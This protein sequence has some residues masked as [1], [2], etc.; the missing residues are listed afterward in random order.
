MA[1]L[2]KDGN[3]DQLSRRGVLVGSAAAGAILSR[4]LTA[5]AETAPPPPEDRLSSVQALIEA[6]RAGSPELGAL[7]ARQ[8]PGLHRGGVAAVT[9]SETPPVPG[10]TSVPTRASGNV[11]A[12][13]GQ[14]FL[15]AVSS[16][17]PVTVSIDERPPAPM[18]RVAGTSY[19]FRLE[20]LRLGTTHTFTYIV[21]DRAVGTNGVAGYNPDSYELPGV[22][23]G[24]LSDM[25]T[26]TSRIYPGATAKYWVYV[27]P[28]A[29]TDR[30]APLMVWQDGPTYVGAA[31]LINYRLQI[32]SDNLVHKKLIPPMVHVLIAPGTGGEPQPMRY[33]GDTQDNE[34]RSLQYDSVSDRYGR[35]LLEDVLP[36]V[37]KT[38]KLRQDSYSRGIAGL[39]SGAICAFNAAWFHP[40]Q[41]SRVH[42][43]IGSYTALQ[44]HPDQHIDGGNI[45]PFT[46][47]REDRKNIR[48]WMSDGMN[49]IDANH[50]G[51]GNAFAAG[52]W[53][54]SNIQLANSL[55]LRGYDFHFRFGVGTHS[56]AQGAMD[57]PE[58]LAWLWR[59]YD[60]AKTSQVYE[61]EEAERLKPLFRVQIANRD[62]W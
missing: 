15:F 56:T 40:D 42:S 54:L 21:G 36:E 10:T 35:Y 6:A 41:F 26:I 59:D 50:D 4:T 47:R 2:D 11:A 16:E 48:I 3:M 12:V 61:M 27:N 57:L 19:W 55:K 22:A 51:L 43:N 29:D 8:L 13:W 37:E 32:V 44:W 38:Y 58:S 23:R 28:G 7:M 14:D 20:T 30:G 62:P 39:S 31:D 24:A 17:Q 53:P 18:I 5:A 9:L 49:D 33:T 25:K 52:S 1:E 60:P 34:M 46:V 45:V